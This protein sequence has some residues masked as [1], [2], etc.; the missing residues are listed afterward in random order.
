MAIRTIIIVLSALS[1]LSSSC[2]GIIR[3]SEYFRRMDLGKEY[4]NSGKHQEAEIEFL[5]VINNREVLPG[6]IA[7]LFGRNSFHLDKYKQGINWLNKYIQLKGTKGRYY[8]PAIHYLQ[9]AEDAYLKIQREK[10]LNMAREISNVPDF[11][12]GGLDKMICPVCHGS[13]V[14]IQ[15][16]YF[17]EV[18]ITCP[19]SGGEPYLSCS[20]YN[21]FMKGELKPKIK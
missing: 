11:D 15:R 12:C 17:E 14:I 19:Y 9:L 16:N 8:E 6:D 4:M 3:D 13:G 5:F 7:Y 1:S 21:L 20:D 18:Y 10:V 2:Q